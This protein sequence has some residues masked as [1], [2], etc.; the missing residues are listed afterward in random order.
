VAAGLRAL[1]AEQPPFFEYT[2]V[3]TFGSSQREID[4]VRDPTGHARRT[5]GTWPKPE[6]RVAEMVVA[7]REAAERESDPEKKSALRKVAEYAGGIGRDLF[8]GIVT[9]MA[10]GG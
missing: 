3:T 9:N 1:A 5:V 7:L 10:P 2:D 8:I 4:N 6:D